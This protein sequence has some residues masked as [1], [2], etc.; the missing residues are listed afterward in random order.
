MNLKNALIVIASILVFSANQSVSAQSG[1]IHPS[2]GSAIQSP[3][4]AD[5]QAEKRD[6]LNLTAEQKAQLKS[7]HQSERDQLRALRNDQA[8][9][10]EQKQ[11]KAQSIRQATRQQQLGILTPQQQQA[12]R[13]NRHERGGRGRGGERG[14]QGEGRE[15]NH[16]LNLTANQ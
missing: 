13:N 12:L 15:A 11:A 5:P 6:H 10:P 7:I 14:P 1:V 2:A 8:L 4:A 9:T 3:Q 16:A